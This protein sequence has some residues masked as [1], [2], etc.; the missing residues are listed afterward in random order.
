MRLIAGGGGGQFADHQ[1]QAVEGLAAGHL[2]RGDARGG[3]GE[4]GFRLRQIRGIAQSGDD[5]ALHPVAQLGL[6]AQ[7]L[8]EGG[9]PFVRGAQIEVGRNRLGDDRHQD[10]SDAVFFLFNLGASGLDRPA[11]AAEDIYLP[12]GIEARLPGGARI[13]Y[14]GLGLGLRRAGAVDATR[15]IDF[16]PDLRAGDPVL[17]A[18]LPQPGLR[19]AQIEIA[20]LGLGHQLI[21]QRIME[22]RPPGRGAGLAI[23]VGAPGRRCGWWRGTVIRSDRAAG[24]G[25]GQQGRGQEDPQMTLHGLPAVVSMNTSI[26]CPA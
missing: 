25:Q 8:I 18:D 23:A 26:C 14:A 4:V 11:G 5:P 22:R 17:G 19:Q 15:S 24:Q 12:A 7:H 10:V 20:G 1:C 3:A 13:I 6:G 9:Q 21:E 2:H 16:G